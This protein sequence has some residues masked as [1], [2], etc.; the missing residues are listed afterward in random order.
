M[1]KQYIIYSKGLNSFISS[2]N[3]LS[4][5]SPNMDNAYKFENIGEAMKKAADINTTLQDKENYYT[6]YPIYN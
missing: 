4:E 3:G 6:V 2:Q 5:V 1:N